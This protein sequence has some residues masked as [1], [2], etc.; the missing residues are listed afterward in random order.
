MGRL[1]LGRDKGPSGVLHGTL[2]LK[3]GLASPGVSNLV[4]IAL[5]GR[6]YFDLGPGMWN[7]KR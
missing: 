2:V 3:L 5:P 4:K 6:K 7:L 1:A